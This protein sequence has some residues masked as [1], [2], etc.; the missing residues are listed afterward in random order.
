MGTKFTYYGGM[1]VLVERSDGFKILCDPY[2]KDNPHTDKT[3][4]DFYDVDLI[5]IT[6]VA[7]DHYGDVEEIFKQGK[8]RVVM[9]RSSKKKMILAG[10][11]DTNRYTNTIY[12]DER[13][14]GQTV[15]HTVRA[16][17]SSTYVEPNGV[18]FSYAPPF[19][20]VIEVEPSVTYYHPGD[21]CL[22]SDMK[23]IQE[24]YHPNIMI[25]GCSNLRENA[26]KDMVPREAAMAVG[27]I[28]PDV[29]IP[30][31]YPLGSKN[32]ELLAEYMK[33]TS[34]R[35]TVMRDINRTFEYMP[36]RVNWL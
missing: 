34:P 30:A 17:H 27:W 8:A 26:C 10:V 23:L 11:M 4:E 28:G 12:G 16:F 1:C 19:G 33:V 9:D 6:H 22:Y 20:Y 5:L 32:P 25:C 7:F 21:T 18:D 35:T 3:P 2:I 14:F 15:I 31:H 24:L 36:A 13:V 29:V